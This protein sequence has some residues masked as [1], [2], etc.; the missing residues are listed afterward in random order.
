MQLLRIDATFAAHTLES[1]KLVQR[2]YKVL[3]DPVW[4]L[5]GAYWAQAGTIASD[6]RFVRSSVFAKLTAVFFACRCDT[7]TG[8]VCALFGLPFE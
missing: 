8:Q 7:D 2:H 4:R 1:G 3:G 6:F 5:Q